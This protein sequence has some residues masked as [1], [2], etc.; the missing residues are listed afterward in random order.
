[1]PQVVE[2]EDRISGEVV[3]PEKLKTYAEVLVRYHLS[4]EDKFLNGRF[5][6]RGRT[7]RR[8]VIATD[9]ALIGKEANQVGESGESDPLVSTTQEFNTMGPRTKLN[10]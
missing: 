1:V 6:N 5:D 3:P 9:F 8:H 4:P 2:A 10:T 7:E